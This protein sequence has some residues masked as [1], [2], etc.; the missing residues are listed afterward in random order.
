MHPPVELSTIEINLKETKVKIR[1]ADKDND[2]FLEPKEF[3]ELCYYTIG[4]TY[5]I[6]SIGL[7]GNKEGKIANDYALEF[8]T[9]LNVRKE[10]LAVYSKQPKRNNSDK[11]VVMKLIP[12][13]DTSF[14]LT[15]SSGFYHNDGFKLKSLF[16]KHFTVQMSKTG[17]LE[18]FFSCQPIEYFEDFFEYLVSSMGEIGFKGV[19]VEE[20]EEDRQGI[21][22]IDFEMNE[23]K[24]D[25]IEVDMELFLPKTYEEECEGDPNFS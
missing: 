14:M 23:G 4:K 5:G 6:A 10:I 7:L 15:L 3:A 20:T 9:R 21:V 1:V 8:L 17:A 12:N 2:G 18:I 11:N 13:E 16:E 24:E 19:S 22:T 25:E